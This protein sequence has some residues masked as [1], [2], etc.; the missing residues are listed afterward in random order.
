MKKI[1]TT[2]LIISFNLTFSQNYFEGKKL[3]CKS[4]NTEAMKLFNLGIETLYLNKSLDQKYLKITSNI[5][6]K[7]YKTDTTF[8]DAI[9]FTGYTLSLLNDK[10]AIACY[11]MADSL[12]KNTLEFKIN[13][14]SEGLRVGNEESLKIARKKYN[15]LINLFPENPEGYYGFALTSPI[16]GDVDKGLENINIA[17]EK[18]KL[19]NLKLKDEVIFLKGVLLSKNKKYDEGLEYLE[20]CYSTYKKD[21]NFKIHY[22]LCLLKVSEIKNDQKMKQKA[23]KFYE[24]IENKEQIPEDIKALL[25]F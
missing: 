17:I 24:Q 13:L 25:K 1:F 20:K 2:L 22:S 4:E 16:F 14:A 8:C 6:F 10:K 21:E 9:F 15:E 3:Y 7:A 23:F 5:F 11:I 12:S 18:Y 19:L